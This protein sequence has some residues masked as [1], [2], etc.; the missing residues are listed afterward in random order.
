VR[1]RGCSG[2]SAAERTPLQVAAQDNVVRA[3]AVDHV[4]G[5]I[6]SATVTPE[7]ARN[8]RN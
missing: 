7:F 6:I 3:G 2:W 1:S 5:S 8:L 4:L